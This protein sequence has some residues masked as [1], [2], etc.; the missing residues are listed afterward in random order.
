MIE[1]GRQKCRPYFVCRA[2][3]RAPKP[4]LNSFTIQSQVC[5]RLFVYDVWHPRYVATVVTFQNVEQSLN[6][7][8]GHAFFRIGR[9]SSDASSAGKMVIQT[10]AIFNFRIEQR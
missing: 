9:K 8:S 3:P 6:A 4:A 2:F 7:T 1:Q 5:P 10:A